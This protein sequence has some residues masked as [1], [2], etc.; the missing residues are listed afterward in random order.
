MGLMLLG[1]VSGWVSWLEG[2]KQCAAG[3][4]AVTSFTV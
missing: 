3:V 4:K 2:W 1:M